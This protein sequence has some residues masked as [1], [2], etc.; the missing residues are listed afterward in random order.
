[1]KVEPGNVSKNMENGG[2]RFLSS[3][4]SELLG[5]SQ[6]GDCKNGDAII[7]SST[8]RGLHNSANGRKLGGANQRRS[9][10]SPSAASCGGLATGIGT[11]LK[12]KKTLFNVKRMRFV[13]K[14][15]RVLRNVT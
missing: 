15:I 12:E 5:L 7:T 1:M 9:S 8:P 3:P 4:H 6:N 10:T 2:S 14:R 13:F 11:L